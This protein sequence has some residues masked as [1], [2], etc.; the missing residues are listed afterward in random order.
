MERE[1]DVRGVCVCWR[2]WSWCPRARGRR[3]RAEAGA[4]GPGAEE[5][6]A[7]EVGPRRRPAFSSTCGSALPARTLTRSRARGMHSSCLYA[8]PSTEGGNRLG[9]ARSGA[10][11][12]AS[13]KPRTS[14]FCA[15]AARNGA[16]PGWVGPP[17]AP[18][19]VLCARLSTWVGVRPC[20]KPPLSRARTPPKDTLAAPARSR[21]HKKSARTFLWYARAAIPRL[22]LGDAARAGSL[23]RRAAD[24]AARSILERCVRRR[25]GERSQGEKNR[26]MGTGGSLRRASSSALFLVLSQT[27]AAPP[28]DPHPTHHRRPGGS[29][30]NV[31]RGRGKRARRRRALPLAHA[32]AFFPLVIVHPSSKPSSATAPPPPPPPSRLCRPSRRPWRRRPRARHPR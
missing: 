13:A 18:V 6:R 7:R 23:A 3:R 24:A 21:T 22:L 26:G 28:P 25:Q 19:G 5:E 1:R 29:T 11:D 20:P 2:W 15:T 12:S 31:W 32:H 17:L 8:L 9:R 30:L 4:V 27:D 14:H 10:R 16:D